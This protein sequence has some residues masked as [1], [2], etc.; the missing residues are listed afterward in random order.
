MPLIGTSPS[1]VKSKLPAILALCTTIFGLISSP[2]V[3][4]ML[5]AKYSA[6]IIAIGAG[7]QAY[8]KSVDHRE[9]Q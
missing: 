2:A 9:G 6:I 4:A 5:P 8:T 7:W 3:L 1:T